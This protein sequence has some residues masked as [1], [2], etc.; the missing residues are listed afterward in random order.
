M[1]KLRAVR[2]RS[3]LVQELVLSM[4]VHYL[5]G[6]ERHVTC[7]RC[8]GA[9]YVVA[10]YPA[11]EY[12]NAWRKCPLCADNMLILRAIKYWYYR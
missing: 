9:V 5:F 7:S 12:Y 1:A 3:A 11:D 6:F 8:P 10:T 2:S 4:V